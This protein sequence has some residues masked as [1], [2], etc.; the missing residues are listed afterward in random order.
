LVGAQQVALVAILLL[1]LTALIVLSL[2]AEAREH[3]P[4]LIR[5]RVLREV[6]VA[7]E[8]T[9]QPGALE[10]LGKAMRAQQGLGALLLI[11]REVAE[12]PV[13]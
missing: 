13:L 2:Q 5:L 7:E 9:L 4:Q 8:T 12:V 1:L 6:P 11:V 3:Y 10:H